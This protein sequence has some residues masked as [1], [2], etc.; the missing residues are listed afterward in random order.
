M[1]KISVLEDGVWELEKLKDQLVVLEQYKKELSD[2][3][4]I[5]QRM[6]QELHQKDTEIAN[7]IS[8]V[9]A[10][11]E[12]EIANSYEEQIARQNNKIKKTR[13]NKAKKKNKKVKERI[14]EETAELREENKKLSEESRY[15]FRKDKVAAI[16]NNRFYYAMFS[17][18]GISDYLIDLLFIAVT[19]LLVP[20]LIYLLA[21][22]KNPVL[23][24]VIMYLIIVFIVAAVYYIAYYGTKRKAP[25]AI[26]KGK[27]LKYKIRQNNRRIRK[28]KRAIVKDK[29]ESIYNLDSY[30]KEIK[31]LEKKVREIELQKGAALLE[32]QNTASSALAK[33]VQ[34]KHE[35][36]VSD[37]RSR[38]QAQKEKT[39]HIEEKVRAVAFDL[40][41]RYQAYLG[42]E[43]MN[44]AAVEELI[45]IMNERDLRAVSEALHIYHAKKME[46]KADNTKSV[47]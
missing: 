27:E 16:Y 10:A 36:E 44:P 22:P 11:R 40:T 37:L 12:Q 15:V 6:E 42:T 8:A 38:Y 34:N 7:E 2:F 19:F 25:D 31:K 21:A 3:D 33:E 35:A 26:V 5:E 20:R 41:N 45:A 28:I 47:S 14:E 32:F 13:E 4:V 46:A 30:D 43:F 1:D 9:I 17:P 29:D 23:F 24:Q 18:K 39:H